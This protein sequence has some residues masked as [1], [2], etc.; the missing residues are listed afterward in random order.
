MYAE[1]ELLFPS[2]VIPKLRESRGEAWTKL[3]DRVS[4]LPENHPDSLAFS[5]MM[6]RLDG[7]MSCETDSYRAM[8]GCL[9]CA[10]QTLRRHKGSDQELLKRYQAASVKIEE[11]LESLP[12]APIYI[13]ARAA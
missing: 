12:T 9:G 10:L 2:H 1:N 5:L 7:C 8:K 13:A 3:V 11:H 6:I 4:R